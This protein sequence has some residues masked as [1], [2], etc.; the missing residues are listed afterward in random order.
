MRYVGRKQALS[1]AIEGMIA[2]ERAGEHFQALGNVSNRHV[3]GR[4]WG[5]V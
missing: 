4:I 3:F 2:K 1:L 5:H